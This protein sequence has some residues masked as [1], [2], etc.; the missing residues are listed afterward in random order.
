MITRAAFFTVFVRT[1]IASR[2]H[3]GEGRGREERGAC[4]VGGAC[5]S[6]PGLNLGR[7]TS[8]SPITRHISHSRRFARSI[9]RCPVTAAALA[10][11]DARRRLLAAGPRRTRRESRAPAAAG[12]L[13]GNC[14][15]YGR[16]ENG[17]SAVVD[18]RKSSKFL[19][20]SSGVPPSAYQRQRLMMNPLISRNEIAGLGSTP[21]Y[22]SGSGFEARFGPF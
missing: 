7:P 9:A 18:K 11:S 20:S 16:A 10:P 1:P 14:V 22:S 17:F 15:Q 4:L 8:A 6:F 2:S 3:R 5:A 12:A 13:K 21:L 19:I